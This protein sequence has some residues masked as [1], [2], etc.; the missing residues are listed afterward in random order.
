[1]LLSSVCFI[2]LKVFGGPEKDRLLEVLGVKKFMPSRSSW[3]GGQPG[4]W[5]GLHPEQW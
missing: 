1:M 5:G 2:S 4:C 3:G